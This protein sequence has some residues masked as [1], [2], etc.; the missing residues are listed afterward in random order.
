M[1]KPNAKWDDIVAWMAENPERAGVLVGMSSYL[2]VVIYLINY[3][4]V[5]LN[6][7]LI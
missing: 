6:L 3:K 5:K 7:L 1:G 4:Q 2:K